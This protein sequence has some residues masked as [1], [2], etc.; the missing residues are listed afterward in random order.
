MNK[1][2]HILGLA[3]VAAAAIVAIAIS[4]DASAS[5]NKCERV[6]SLAGA[7]MAARQ[8]GEPRKLIVDALDRQGINIH[9]VAANIVDGA[10]M[11][12]RYDEH[13]ARTRAIQDFA[14]TWRAVCVVY[15]KEE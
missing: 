4:G 1:L 10:F 6:G 9:G 11:R 14:R 13:A 3:A 5:T 8:E 12:E 2:A 15:G 7:V